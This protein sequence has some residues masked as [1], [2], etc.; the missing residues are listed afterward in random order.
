MP[1]IYFNNESIF[2]VIRVLNSYVCQKTA[3]AIFEKKA[4]VTITTVSLTIHLESR[5]WPPC[6]VPGAPGLMQLGG[7]I[8]DRRL[9]DRRPLIG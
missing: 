6:P 4:F 2:H 9:Q 3:P 1:L 7:D 5:K 8:K